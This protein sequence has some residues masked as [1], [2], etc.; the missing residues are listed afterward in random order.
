MTGS[1]RFVT[2]TLTRSDKKMTQEQPKQDPKSIATE[3]RD[4]VTSQLLDLQISK[5]QLQQQ[6]QQ[7]Q[8]QLAQVE[9]GIK[10]TEEYLARINEALND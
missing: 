8:S 7:V 1:K 2:V 9:Q 10:A 4:N 3:V 5:R 6:A